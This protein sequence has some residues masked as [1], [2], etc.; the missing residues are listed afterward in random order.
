MFLYFTVIQFLRRIFTFLKV[1]K[2]LKLNNNEQYTFKIDYVLV[3]FKTKL[4]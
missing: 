4:N 1:C 2:I 3:I